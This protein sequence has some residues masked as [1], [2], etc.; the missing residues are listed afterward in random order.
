MRSAITPGA[1]LRPFLAVCVV[2]CGQMRAGA[3]ADTAEDALLLHKLAPP[4]L[5]TASQRFGLRFPIHRLDRGLMM[6]FPVLGVDHKPGDAA[7]KTDCYDYAGRP[8][9][10]CYGDHDGTDFLLFGSFITMDHYD[11]RVVAAA[12]GVVIELEDGNYDRCHADTSDVSCDGHPMQA[13]YVTL[14]HDNGFTTRYLHLKK[15]SIV[16]QVGMHVQCGDVLGF[17][18]S[19]GHS[20][21]PHLHFELHDP[22]GALVDPYAGPKSQPTSYW[23][24]QDGPDGL[25]GDLCAGEVATP[26]SCAWQVKDD[27]TKCGADLLADAVACGTSVVTSAEACGTALVTSAEQCG[28]DLITSAAQCGTDTVTDAVRCG[29]QTLSNLWDCVSHGLS[30]SSCTVALTCQVPRSCSVPKTCA[31]PRTCS[32]PNTCMVPKSCDVYSCQ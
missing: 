27:A 10:L 6:A 16:V 14:R 23:L 22:S 8:A 21:T 20:A 29:T 7:S 12:P 2:S 31:V 24:Q 15:G 9:P 19:S 1:F 18:G 25:P 32:S 28:S 13:N 11:T 5:S 3:P 4:Q 30:G 17:V 26:V